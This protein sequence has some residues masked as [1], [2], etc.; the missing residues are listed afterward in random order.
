[1]AI[2]VRVVSNNGITGNNQGRL[3]VLEHSI[4]SGSVELA[5]SCNNNGKV[6]VRRY[7][8]DYKEVIWEQCLIN[9][10]GNLVLGNKIQGN[11]YGF[12]PNRR[13]CEV[14]YE[15]ISLD[16]VQNITY[17]LVEL[18]KGLTPA[19]GTLSPFFNTT[20]NKLNVY[21]S[22]ESLQFKLNLIGSWVGAT[23]NRSI[24][25]DFLD[26]IGNRLVVNRPEAVG[27]DALSLIGFLSIDVGG[28]IAT[29]GTAI[30]IVSNGG[31]YTV[32]DIL[33]IAEQNSVLDEINV[34]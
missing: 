5:S 25:V 20:S 23:S 31:T 14:H 19:T 28:N 1:M 16:L 30:T 6:F 27:T 29:N 22:N 33:L 8:K 17:N 18:V 26:T 12:V 4:D 2:E 34:R 10:E 24:Q 32:T 21:D 9:G 13:K 7:S 11:S 3:K 15:S